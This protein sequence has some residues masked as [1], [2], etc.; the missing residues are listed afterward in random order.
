M[1]QIIKAGFMHWFLQRISAICLLFSLFILFILKNIAI[2]T[3]L[4][5]LVFFHLK[6]GFETLIED[7][8]HDSY[9]KIFGGILLQLIVIYL[10]KFIFLLAII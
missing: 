4:F 2:T 6:I 8:I 5:I 10:I 3:V 7:Y 9:L 1:I